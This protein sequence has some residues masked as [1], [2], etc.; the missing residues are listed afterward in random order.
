[1]PVPDKAG[2]ELI[3]RK[4]YTTLNKC[5]MNKHQ[6]LDIGIFSFGLFLGIFSPF[7]KGSRFLK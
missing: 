6:C 2:M 3:S 5:I 7:S 4:S 1:M